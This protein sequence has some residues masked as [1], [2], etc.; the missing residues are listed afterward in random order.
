MGYG[1]TTA[2][3][4][5]IEAEKINPFWFTFP[6][7]S[8]SEAV[9]WDKFTDEIVRQD[10]HAG[11]ALKSLGI[12]SDAPQMEK[13][14]QIFSGVLPAEN[15]FMILDDYQFTKSAALKK[16]IM[17]LA[18]EELDGLHILLI[19]R[20]T[21]DID[22]VELLSKGLCYIL[23][24]QHLKFTYS[25][26]QDYCRRVHPGITDEDL[27]KI[28]E[29]T[30]GWISFIYI[31]L[32]G[33]KNGIPVG[34]S[35]MIEEMV[36]KALFAPYDKDMQSFLLK[37]SVL[38]DFTAEQAKCVT[39]NKNTKPLLKKLTRENGFVFYD[40]KSKTYKIHSVLL[41][42]LRLKQNFSAEEVCEFYTRL[43]DW[44]LEK[45]EFQRAYSCL[46]QAGLTERILSHLN[47]P[48]NIRN[49]L[50]QFEGVDAMFNST[51]REVLFEYP[52]AY[53]L[54]I[55]HSIVQG[56]QNPILGWA[57]RLNE[58][59][60][61]YKKQDGID[62]TYRNRILGETL[63]VRILTYFNY[64]SEMM[65]Q[66]QEIIR[67][68]NGQHS[69]LLLQ[70]YTF[71]FGSPHYLYIYFREMGSLK[72]ISDVLAKSTDFTEFS[73]GCGAGSSFLALAEYA[74][75][76][77][78]FDKVEKHVLETI[79]KAET[80]SQIYI[81]LCARFC[82]IRL[83]I[84]EGRLSEALEL[85]KELQ[86]D[87][88]RLNRPLYNTAVDLCSGYIFASICQFEQI[89]SWLQIG[90]MTSASFYSQGLS[91]IYIVYGKAVMTSKKYIKLET[92]TT[93]FKKRFSLFSNQ[94]GLIYN[95]IFEAAARCHLHGTSAGAA[96]L[97]AALNEA[98]P[99]RLITPFAES[100]PH[101]IA[102]LQ[103]IVQKHPED[104]YLST[105]LTLCLRYERMIQG[106]SYHPAS[107]SQR[108]IDILSL[109]AEGLSR[110]EMAMR[111]FIS[112]ETVKTHFKNI[113]QKLSVS[114]KI[115]AVKIA[116]DRGCLKM[117]DT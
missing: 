26:T 6:D 94:L 19:T 54:H 2:V 34:L 108:E 50:L 90:D 27:S 66:N 76:T 23:S 71:T 11:F 49:V 3:K 102:M 39:K 106:L 77:G 46:N 32:L 4:K 81:I 42:Y 74:L 5:F 93:E 60:R 53:L 63:I 91:Y 72:K 18:R 69:Y 15:F 36:E 80:M 17:R 33:I 14:L 44:Y 112:E 114:S 87:A 68:L 41:D 12:P 9:F 31:I 8:G 16:L 109:A 85:L 75:E 64:F 116:Q 40:E 37:L 10:A 115:S 89:P 99:D 7:L 29:Y 30:D 82:L 117:S 45:Q 58:L 83:R 111:L 20:D 38:E 78:A 84:L 28:Y 95:K 98:R 43:G 51:P 101:I 52:L 62:E 56:K 96:V 86:R 35:T 1:K 55:F 22:F 24:R 25:E 61:Y 110:K 105:I 21:T 92:L 104:E 100:A 65:T 48:Q 107:L 73:N 79:E 97:E 113:Y 57:E 67:L 88:E 103:Y 59:E 47:N 70:G 13:V